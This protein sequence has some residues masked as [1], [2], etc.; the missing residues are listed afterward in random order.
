MGS[1]ETHS[2]DRL[3]GA[4]KGT[5]HVNTQTVAVRTWRKSLLAYEWHREVIGTW[6]SFFT[7][8]WAT[9]FSEQFLDDSTPTAPLS[10]VP[11]RDTESSTLYFL[12]FRKVGSR[13]FLRYFVCIS[14]LSN[15]A[16]E[17]SWDVLTTS[18]QRPCRAFSPGTVS[19]SDKDC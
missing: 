5:L 1:N 10:S 3:S 2:H 14:W 19:V 15:R 8:E 18:G 11:C 4:R 6:P 12:V 16:S 13:C 9:A 7:Q 17:G